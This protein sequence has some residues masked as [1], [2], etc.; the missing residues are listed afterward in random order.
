MK[1]YFVFVLYLVVLQYGF[2][3]T[4]PLPILQNGWERIVI[5]NIGNFDIPPTMELQGGAYL[6]TKNA[7][8]NILKMNQSTFQ[9]IIQQKGLNDLTSEGYSRYARVMFKTDMGSRDSELI[10][11]FDVKQF[12]SDDISGLNDVYK[13]ALQIGFTNSGQK[14]LEW[15][16]LKI[17]I[18]NGMSCI[19]TN[20]KRQLNNNEPVIVHNYHFFNYDYEH[21]LIL[22]YRQNERDYWEKD[23][24]TILNSLRLR[25]RK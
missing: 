20:Y 24:V 12:T 22:S 4:F 25:K 2:S 9:I 11:D 23:F 19:H 21:T 14:L 3:Q 8:E 1:K 15:Y 7:L 16:P 5:E 17:E 6:K 18:I 10:L 13:R